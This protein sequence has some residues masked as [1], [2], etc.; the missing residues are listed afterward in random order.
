MVIPHVLAVLVDS[1]Q[2]PDLEHVTESLGREDPDA[3]TLSLEQRIEAHRRA[4]QEVRRP[5]HSP[6]LDGGRDDSP[7][8][9]VD[10][11]R[12]GRALAHSDQAGVLV[13]EDQVGEGA[14][15]VDAD[16]C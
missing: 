10:R 16:S 4:V 14:A 5:T 13:E 7:N 15:D 8:R 9:R 11:G 12:L 2:P 6:L 1:H 3:G